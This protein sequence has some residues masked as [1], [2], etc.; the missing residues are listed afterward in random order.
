MPDP[1]KPQE[2][3]QRSIDVQAVSGQKIASQRLI[4]SEIVLV[5]K[6]GAD[7]VDDPAQTLSFMKGVVDFQISKDFPRVV[8]GISALAGAGYEVL[9]DDLAA[10]GA[11]FKPEMAQR[12][13]LGA[14]DE[15]RG[16]P[17]PRA[18]NV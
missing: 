12:P 2:L 18:V 13:G 5:L 9:V 6:F 16:L 3:D 15:E 14:L 7:A 8:L 10:A 11:N 1:G 4:R 17:A